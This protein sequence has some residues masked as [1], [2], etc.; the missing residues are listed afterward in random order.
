MEISKIELKAKINNHFDSNEF[1]ALCFE[2]NGTGVEYDNLE[3]VTKSLKIQSLI[4]FLDRRKELFKLVELCEKNRPNVIW[5]NRQPNLN[6]DV[7]KVEELE[8]NL[9]EIVP[10]ITAELNDILQSI[11]SNQ[12]TL[13]EKFNGLLDE[14]LV[15]NSKQFDKNDLLSAKKAIRHLIDGLNSEIQEVKINS[16]ILAYDEFSKLINLDSDNGEFISIGYW[17]N[18]HYFTLLN[19]NKNATIQ[20]YECASRFPCIAT[21]I[22]PVIFFGTDYAKLLH[23][24]EVQLKKCME[25]LIIIQAAEG[26]IEYLAWAALAGGFLVPDPENAYRLIAD[27]NDM[28]LTKLDHLKR[29]KTQFVA[30]I[31]NGSLSC[32]SEIMNF[33]FESLAMGGR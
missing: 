1:Q 31:V 3:G 10:H 20:V 12:N 30:E 28:Q 2:L 14:Q 27:K 23:E 32:L 19:D 4:A 6:L 22:F 29:K 11:D 15:M 26:E 17:G 24:V 8:F 21:K 9:V 33:D 16:F 13:Q 25:E 18:F 7:I 5:Q